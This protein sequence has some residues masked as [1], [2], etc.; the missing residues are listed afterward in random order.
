MGASARQPLRINQ[1]DLEETFGKGNMYCWDWMNIT[2]TWNKTL[3]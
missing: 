1:M 3:E 2:V